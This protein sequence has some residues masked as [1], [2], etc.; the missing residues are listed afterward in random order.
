MSDHR[1]LELHKQAAVDFLQL[2]VAGQINQAYDRHVDM[3]GKHHNPFFAAGFS[4]LKQAMADIQVQ[5]PTKQLTVKHV[6]GDGD[7]VA[8]HSHL[9]VQPGEPGMSV[10]HLFRFRAGKIVEL[11]DVGQAIP[12]QSP[13]QD[14]AF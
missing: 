4:A 13:N 12:E 11:W 2:V 14:G 5:A 6:L 1:D 8:V 3:T 9:N 7:L 10:L